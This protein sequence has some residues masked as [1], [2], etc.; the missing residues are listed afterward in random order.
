[1]AHVTAAERRPQLIAAAVSLMA[2][3]GV[4]AGSTRAIAAELGVAQATV[5]YTFGTKADL[6]RAVLE[7]LTED[8]I[9][10]VQT[11][12]EHATGLEEA[13][14]LTADAFLEDLTGRPDLNLL[15]LELV[16]HSLRTPEL[17]TVVARYHEETAA[18]AANVLRRLSERSGQE[19]AVEPEALGRF[20]VA[21]LDGLCMH[22]VIQGDSA[23]GE[24]TRR[25]LDLLVTATAALAYGRDGQ[26]GQDGQRGA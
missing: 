25:A 19:Y 3:E 7:T 24:E 16:A 23:P 11:A 4:A 8:V 26:S 13:M 22:L 2:R 9:A 21:G 14:R 10:R 1:M 6:Y 12:A 15:W 18:I 17:R 20:L 5:H